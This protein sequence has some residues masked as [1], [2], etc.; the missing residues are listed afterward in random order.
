M[1]DLSKSDPEPT[2]F[3]VS[4]A[5]PGEKFGAC[6]V[7]VVS[8]TSTVSHLLVGG[9]S[10]NRTYPGL[11]V[12]GHVAVGSTKFHVTGTTVLPSLGDGVTALSQISALQPNFVLA[13]TD[14]GVFKCAL[15]DCG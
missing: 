7:R 10:T 3:D 2:F 1:F 5:V 13:A 8:A 14:V 15:L 11:L 4:A 9:L 12:Y 6:A